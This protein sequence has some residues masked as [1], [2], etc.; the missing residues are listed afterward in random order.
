MLKI[1]IVNR[2]LTKYSL[3][4]QIGNT[5]TYCFRKMEIEGFTYAIHMNESSYSYIRFTIWHWVYMHNVV[6][7]SI[8]Q[9]CLSS[10]WLFSIYTYL[11]IHA[12]RWFHMLIYLCTSNYCFLFYGWLFRK[13]AKKLLWYLL[14][15]RKI[16]LH[17]IGKR[18]VSFTPDEVKCFFFLR[19]NEISICIRTIWPTCVRAI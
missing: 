6:C 11:H 15:F 5:F 19:K 2:K 13:T 9:T 17:R 10:G 14:E 12:R 18:R 8:G 16:W 4:T 1:Q 7:W 3:S